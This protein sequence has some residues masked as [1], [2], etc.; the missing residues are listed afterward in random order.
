[1]ITYQP[2]ILAVYAQTSGARIV[3]PTNSSRLPIGNVNFSIRAPP[4][5]GSGMVMELRV[6]DF[7]VSEVI[8]DVTVVLNDMPEDWYVSAS[9]CIQAI[10]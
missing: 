6:N 8:E 4:L 1:M 2:T 9:S 5:A 10:K 7:L 3:S